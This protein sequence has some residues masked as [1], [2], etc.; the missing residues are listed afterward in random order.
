MLQIL[1][2]TTRNTQQLWLK[3]LLERV[4]HNNLPWL[5]EYYESIGWISIDVADRLLAIAEAEKVRYNGPTWTLSP[6]EHRTS[7]LFI[8]RLLGRQVDISLLPISPPARASIVH[9]TIKPREGYLEAHQQEKKDLEFAVQR[10]EV[11]IKNLE[12]ELEKRDVEIGKLKERLKE[13]EGQND[14]FLNELKKNR[15]YREILE[16]NLRLRKAAFSGKG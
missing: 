4:G 9:T 1:D 16:E 13:L 11:T 5:L 8:E 14:E 10:R 15:V 12:Q 2:E 3:F 6:E 7:M